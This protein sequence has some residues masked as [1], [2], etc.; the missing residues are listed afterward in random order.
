MRLTPLDIRKQEFGRTLRGYDPEEVKAFLELV[1][2][3][4][5]KSDREITKL[6]ERSERLQASVDDYRKVEQALQSTLVTTQQASEDAKVTAS[7]EAELILR[8][9]EM[10]ARQIVQDARRRADDF[11]RDIISLEQQRLAFIAKF[12]AFILTQ[13]Q[14][15]AAFESDE[16]L[17]AAVE[18][19]RSTDEEIDRMLVQLESGRQK[20]AE[21]DK[22]MGREQA[23]EVMPTN[24]KEQGSS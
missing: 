1:A 6:R 2:T 15:I 4:L 16:R 21:T 24:S 23:G 17:E 8:E 10:R 7:K 13:D 5:E 14:L 22:S 19:A 11:E 9:A 20:R 3:E 18:K 12:R